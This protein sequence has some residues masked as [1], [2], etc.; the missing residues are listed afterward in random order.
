MIPIGKLP[1][2]SSI[3][4]PSSSSILLL[5]PHTP[6]SYS[7]ILCSS[8][9]PTPFPHHKNIYWPLRF[10]VLILWLR[11]SD[12]QDHASPSGLH[13]WD[14]SS[15]AWF[16]F[17][18][19]S[20]GYFLVLLSSLRMEW[21]WLVMGHGQ[22]RAGKSRRFYPLLPFPVP[23]PYEVSVEWWCEWY[24]LTSSWDEL[25]LQ[26]LHIHQRLR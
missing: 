15:C 6:R 10:A 4:N 20:F 9:T 7:S 19:F 26:C 18:K 23:F 1:P 3:R 24:T 11:S 13:M 2:P 22:S 17:S 14:D 8:S 12:L 21:A 16:G 5:I 25:G